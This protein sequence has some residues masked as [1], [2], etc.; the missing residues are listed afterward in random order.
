MTDAGRTRVPAVISG[1]IAAGR[2]LNRGVCARHLLYV[3]FVTMTA[4]TLPDFGQF[5]SEASIIR[6]LALLMFSAVGGLIPGTLFSLV[7][8]S[9]ARGVNFSRHA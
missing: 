6:H 7:G 1:N 3:G 5:T 2:L 9:L 8:F 4:A